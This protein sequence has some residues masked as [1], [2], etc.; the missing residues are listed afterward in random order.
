MNNITVIIPVHETNDTVVAQLREA[1]N[2]VVDNTK[3]YSGH[4]DTAIV[5]PESVANELK[6]YIDVIKE[7]KDYNDISFLI[8]NG[9]TDFC[10]QV[11]YAAQNIENEYFSILEYDDVYTNNWFEMAKEYFYGNANVSVFLPINVQT[12]ADRTAW[13]FGNE[14]VWASS[15]SNKIGYI[16]FDCLQNC[17]T[18]NLTGGI[19][20]KSDFLKIGMLKPSIKVA[21]N[22]EF[23]LRLTNNKLEAFVVPKEGYLHVIGRENSLTDIYSKTIKDDEIVKWFEL[24]MR[25]YPYAV[26]RNKDIIRNTEEEVK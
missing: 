23:L 20:N 18:F 8:N 21:F 22:Y 2:S 13:Q 15:F 11:N 9:D 24:A 14:I 17:S 12:N 4:L 19:F 16:D 6:G 26:D 25:E 3:T 10:S 7:E 1:I 5:C